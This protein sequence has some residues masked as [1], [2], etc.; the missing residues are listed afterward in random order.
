[1]DGRNCPYEPAEAE[2]ARVGEVV[3]RI[4]AAFYPQE[5]HVKV[6]LDFFGRR[7]YRDGCM[8]YK[9]KQVDQH[10]ET[11]YM[12]AVSVGN[13]HI[14]VFKSRQIDIGIV[15]IPVV[16]LLERAHRTVDKNK[17]I[18][19]DKESAVLFV[20]KSRTSSKKCQHRYSSGPIR[21][22]ISNPSALPL[23]FIGFSNGSNF[24][25]P[26]TASATERLI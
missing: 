18:T 11:A 16:E 17:V 26:L 7:D 3:P 25:R 5:I 19:V 12:V 9:I 21:L 1:M 22:R 13:E 24:I 14:H 15:Q 10:A 20:S 6:V 2:F 4:V 8:Q 23:S